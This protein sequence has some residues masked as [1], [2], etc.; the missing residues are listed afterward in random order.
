MKH[1]GTTFVETTLIEGHNKPTKVNSTWFYYEEQNSILIATGRNARWRGKSQG[2]PLPLY[3][4]LF[5]GGLPSLHPS[6]IAH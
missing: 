5:K 1:A 6:C 3:E 2:T 4:T